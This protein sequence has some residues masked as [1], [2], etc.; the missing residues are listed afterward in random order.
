MNLLVE[1]VLAQPYRVNTEDKTV[2]YYTILNNDEDTIFELN[3]ENGAK[4]SRWAK[5]KTETIGQKLIETIRKDTCFMSLFMVDVVPGGKV[6]V[7]RWGGAGSHVLGMRIL[8]PAASRTAQYNRQT[9]QQELCRCPRQA[10][11]RS[12]SPGSR[13][14]QPPLP[15]PACMRTQQPPQPGP[16]ADQRLAVHEPLKILSLRLCKE[17]R[18]QDEAFDDPD[19]RRTR[20]DPTRPH[21]AAAPPCPWPAFPGPPAKMAYDAHTHPARRQ[22]TILHADNYPRPARHGHQARRAFTRR[23]SWPIARAEPG[24]L[25][26]G[27]P[28][29]KMAG[30]PAPAA[31]IALAHRA[32]IGRSSSYM[33]L[34]PES[35]VQAIT[36][37]VVHS[38]PEVEPGHAPAPN[39]LSLLV[40]GRTP[41][42]GLA[43]C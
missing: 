11:R 5:Y 35:A 25:R 14:N 19:P 26:F 9:I 41:A 27:P 6:Q 20:A 43:A 18:V 38:A 12:G 33:P 30:H 16:H 1:Q 8:R 21:A 2:Y 36:T 23:I 4:L 7:L 22:D 10:A 40:A 42:C 37:Q 34:Q 17:Q 24:E 39:G 32:Q 13:R 28:L 31:Q 3:S 29:R 15:L